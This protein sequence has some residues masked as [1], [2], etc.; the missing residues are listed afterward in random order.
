MCDHLCIYIYIYIYVCVCLWRCGCGILCLRASYVLMHARVYVFSFYWMFR[1]CTPWPTLPVHPFLT[2]RYSSPSSSCCKTIL[3]S[4]ANSI[5]VPKLAVPALGDLEG[6][7]KGYGKGIKRIN[8]SLYGTI[9]PFWNLES[10]IASSSSSSSSSSLSC[11][12]SCPNC[13]THS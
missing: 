7:C 13:N 2:C 5:Q 3:L 12:S 10:S 11:H 8:M 1:M 4:M 6:L 9:P